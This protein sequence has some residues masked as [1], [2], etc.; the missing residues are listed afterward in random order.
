MYLSCN[1]PAVLL[2]KRHPMKGMAT[3]RLKK[4]VWLLTGWLLLAAGCVG[5]F[6]PIPGGVLLIVLSLVVLSSEY[7]WANHL[8]GRL[9]GRFPKT[10][11][12]VEK[13][14]GR[15]VSAD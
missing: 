8:I 5:L 15:T 4:A 6:L 10:V 9:R 12:A 7:V 14:S 13:Y 1:F 11:T 2:G 3:A